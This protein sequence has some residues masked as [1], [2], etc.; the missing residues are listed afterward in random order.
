MPTATQTETP[1]SQSTRDRER[2]SAGR[3]RTS[4]W[5]GYVMA[6]AWVTA[7]TLLT[8]V[9]MSVIGYERVRFV[10]IFYFLAVFASAWFGGLGPGLLTVLL[11]AWAVNYFF[12]APYGYLS[13]R[14]DDL[15]QTGAFAL[16]SSLIVLLVE[17]GR[18]SSLAARRS[19]E[20]LATTLKSIGD[21]VIATDA[22]GRIQFMNEVAERLTG[23]SYREAAG[24]PLAEVF[25]IINE[26]TRQ[27]VES[28][29]DKVLREGLTV[30]LANHTLLVARDGREIPI[31]D[32][33]APV[34]GEGGVTEGVVLVFHDASETRRAAEAD[35]H[36]AAVFESVT[37]PF[38]AFDSS[39]RFT[40]VNERAAQVL[41]RGS[42]ELLGQVLWD[43]FPQ[44]LEGKPY[45]ELRRAME[46]RRKVYLEY[47]S[48]VVGTW[49][50]LNAYPLPD[51]GMS[52]YFRDISERR[53]AEERQRALLSAI[54]DLMFRIRRDG[55]L[56]D[57]NAAR[58]DGPALSPEQLLGR[59]IADVLPDEVARLTLLHA[60]RAL[61]NG[62]IEV[63]EYDL[64]GDGTR[65]DYEAR[66]VASGDDEVLAI[67]RNVTEGRRAETERANL[68]AQIESERVRLRD[69]ISS[70]PGV[71][72]EAWGTP[73][74]AS[75]RIN[76]VSDYVE[77][78]LGYTVEEWLATPNFWLTIVHPEDRE[79]AAA[80][81]AEHFR[82]GGADINRFRWITKDGRVLHIESHSV[83]INDA[84]GRPL[85]MRGVTLDATERVRAEEELRQRREQLQLALEA[86]DFGICEWDLTDNSLRWSREH[87]ELLGYEPFSFSPTYKHWRER[88]HPED[89]PAVEAEFEAAK[90]ER[91]TTAYDY[92]VLLPSGEVRWMHLRGRFNYDDAGRAVSLNGLLMDVTE[93]KLSEE[94]LRR[95]EERYRALADAMPQIVW[96][97]RPD[98]YIDYYNRRWFEYTG[99]GLPETEGWHW[100]PLVHPLDIERY[101]RG[102]TTSIVTGRDFNAQL[103][104]RRADGQFRWHL[105]RAEPLRDE[106]GHVLRWFGTATDIHDQKQAEEHLSFLVESSGLLASSLDYETTLDR[107]A[108][109]AVSSLADYCLI[110][111]VGD[112][113][114]IRRVAA[115][116]ADAGHDQLV[117]ELR[118]F[119]PDPEKSIGVPNVLREGETLIVHEVTDERLRAL[120]RDEEHAALLRRLGLKSFM[121]IPLVARGRIIGALTCAVTGDRPAYTSDEVAFA[122]ELARRAALAIDNARLFTETQEANRSK[123]EFLA[124]LSHELRT[125]LTPILGWTHMIRNG[126]LAPED[127]AHGMG[128]IE[129]NSEA[130]SRLINDLLD[131]SSI[132]SGKMRIERES[133]ELGAVVREAAETVRPQAEA[134]GLTLEVSTGGLS[135]L[136]VSGD[137]T[138]LVQVFWNLL[139][140]SVKF[141]RAGGRIS[142]RLTETGGAARIIVEDDGQGIAPEFLPYVFERFRQ[143]DGSTTRAHGGLGIGLALV[144]SF[145]E[146]HGGRV[147]AESDGVGRGSRFTITLPL[148]AAPPKSAAADG[149]PAAEEEPC[150]ENICRI[151]LVED[152]RDTLEMLRVVFEARGY[153]TIACANAEEA[154]RAAESQRFDFVVSDIGLPLVD[155]YEL[156]RRLRALP[157]MSDTPA[158]ALTGYAA[159]KDAEAALASGFDAHLAKPVDP[160]ILTEEVERLLQRRDGNA[161]A[162]QNDGAT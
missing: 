63:F 127:T 93:R 100:Q 79:R 132:M 2:A 148:I 47:R 39:W 91:R 45:E 56:L 4:A 116:H 29:V 28:P 146:A 42:E 98:G 156:I 94:R 114:R 108:N 19:S 17:R 57:Y 32:S 69:I 41:G 8:H 13:L 124:T 6:L 158:L 33:G 134:R 3:P 92:R 18:R 160:G 153:T 80:H 103:R 38:V 129:K 104:L 73:D 83:T 112:D 97:A 121:T 147:A 119:P 75:Q 66:V 126:H 22:E 106:T 99:R 122:E 117:A 86:A 24:R 140:N 89:L 145:V 88:A 149:E 10:S 30:G 5:T 109:L 133:V 62:S 68:A 37:D 87:Y 67:V 35:R 76:F 123:D 46:E 77:Q 84:E 131:M 118:R 111:V 162:D 74:R 12:L 96:A 139:N 49:I 138:R 52:F 25:R 115:A 161:P 16:V 1:E 48:P 64:D 71:V 130:L 150:A 95:S 11:S 70:V 31:E 51:G 128:V 113:G 137:R 90:A 154:L 141:S 136:N 155:G 157:H 107:L 44:T 14:P 110:D 34:R 40:Y 60:E 105:S 144:K 78:M 59:N 120:A 102:W 9:L 82:R 101:L 7:A 36:L 15:L 135:R 21:A 65:K 53:E 142:I 55:R 20:Q 26:R 58:A 125:P 72:W 152:A 81:A 43:V 23:W 151:L 54:P 143:A 50:E 85:G 61:E 159:T 27:P